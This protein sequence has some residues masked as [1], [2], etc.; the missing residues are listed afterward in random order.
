MLSDSSPTAPRVPDPP[1]TAADPETTHDHASGSGVIA[2]ADELIA[3]VK[4]VLAF[5]HVGPRAEGCDPVAYPLL[6]PLLDGPRRVGDLAECVRT[7]VT[8]VSRYGSALVAA[9]LASKTPDPDDR[10]AQLLA[11]TDAGRALAAD[12]RAYRADRFSR[13]LRDWTPEEIA[14][15]LGHLSR[16][17]GDLNQA[18]A[19]PVATTTDE[20]D[21]QQETL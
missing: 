14:D 18:R 19:E 11:L 8:A 3:L 1:A 20:P 4:T 7:D 17:R 13:A 6:F 15:L 16:L 2:L 10:R 5:K 9:G 21:H 12:I